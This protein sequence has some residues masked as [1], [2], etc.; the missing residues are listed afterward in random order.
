MSFPWE[1]RKFARRAAR[2]VFWRRRGALLPMGIAI[3]SIQAL[4]HAGN[5]VLFFSASASAP[6]GLWWLSRCPWEYFYCFFTGPAFTSIFPNF[7]ARSFALSS[8]V[9]LSRDTPLCES[10][11]SCLI[12]RSTMNLSEGFGVQNIPLRGPQTIPENVR[13]TRRLSL[14]E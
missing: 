8:A 5:S 7:F 14:V 3:S 9:L 4:F 2:S 13:V 1:Q 10:K 6:P 11:V 12:L